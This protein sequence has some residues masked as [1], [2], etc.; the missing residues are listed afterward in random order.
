L[1]AAIVNGG[2]TPRKV[3]FSEIQKPRELDLDLGS[4]HTAYHR[5]SLIDLYPHTKFH[6]NRKKNFFGRTDVRKDVR[7][8]APTYVLTGIS[9]P[10]YLGKL[11]LQI[12]CRYWRK[13]SG[14]GSRG[15]F[16]AFGRT[17]PNRRTRKPTLWNDSR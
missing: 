4:G 10:I 12:F 6:W 3:Q 2:D 13:T 5:A 14:Y 7:T 11:K 9:N 8:W 15:G 16:V 1:P 17:P